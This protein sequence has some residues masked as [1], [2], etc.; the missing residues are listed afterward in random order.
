MSDK[1]RV[2]IVDEMALVLDGL[3]RV[4]ELTDGL[5]VVG[6]ATHSLEAVELARKVSPDV[7]LMDVDI[8]RTN[9]VEA[10]NR[11]Q[12]EGLAHSVV[13]LSF[14]GDSKARW[15]AG[16]LG[17]ATL[18]E[19]NTP[20]AELVEIIRESGTAGADEGAP[21]EVPFC[22]RCALGDVHAPMEEAGYVKGH[23]VVECPECGYVMHQDPA[24]DC[25]SPQSLASRTI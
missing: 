22:P 1:V 13:I 20:I 5:E 15:K 25:P 11:I 8:P 23:K 9:E 21:A 2:L 19:K 10:I 17:A 14:Y 6:T 7:V 4:F 24:T 3:K 16:P 12:R 18:V